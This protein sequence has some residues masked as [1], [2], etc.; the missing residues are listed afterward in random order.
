MKTFQNLSK[1]G[2]LG[3]NRVTPYMHI[4]L[5]HIPFMVQLYG[6]LRAYSGQAVEK[7]NDV[8]KSTHQKSS[9]KQNQT[10]DELITRKRVELLHL[11]YCSWEKRPYM[12]RSLNFW[13]NGKQDNIQVK[14]TT[15]EKVVS[16]AHEKYI[17]ECKSLKEIDEM[18]VGEIKEM[19]K[20]LGVVTRV[21]KKEKLIEL[22]KTSQQ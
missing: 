14:R 7:L 16:E 22:I 12:K 17:D 11:E 9:N 20:N 15:I 21:R 18:T 3:Y 5:Y 13:E 1:K 2:R 4:L 8:L 6:P 19:L 10:H